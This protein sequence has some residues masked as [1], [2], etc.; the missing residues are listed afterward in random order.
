MVELVNRL[1][2]YF[3]L[4][5]DENTG[6]ALT[7]NEIQDAHYQR[8]SQLQLVAFKNFKRPLEEFYLTNIAKI[9]DKDSF[10]S[11]I[12][13]LS[14]EELIKLCELVYIR[15]K[16]GNEE[17]F[18]RSFLLEALAF[19][20]QRP[21]NPIDI[22][23]STPLYPTEVTLFDPKLLQAQLYNGSQTLSIPKLGT[24]FLSVFDYFYRNFYLYQ[25]E[26]LY[27]IWQDIEDV[28][29]R[30]NATY[31]ASGGGSTEFMGWARMGIRVQGMQIVK[32]S[33]PKLGEAV[34]SEVLAELTIDLSKLSEKHQIEWM[35]LKPFDTLFLTLV[36]AKNMND[37]EVNEDNTLP[38]GIK[39]IRGCE[40]AQLLTPDGK[41]IDPYQ[42]QSPDKAFQA[43]DGRYL[44][45]RVKLDPNQYTED[46]KLIQQNFMPDIYTNF[47]LLIRRNPRENQFKS[48]L[49]TIRDLIDAGENSIPEWLKGGLLGYDDV[50]TLHYS[51]LLEGEAENIDFR[52]TFLDSDHLKESFSD[53]KFIINSEV[54][55]EELQP[56]FKIEFQG[57][58][59]KKKKKL[60]KSSASGKTTLSITSYKFPNLGPFNQIQQNLNTIK[61]TPT[62]VEAIRSGCNPGLTMIVGPPGTGKTDV[63]VQIISNLYHNNPNQRVL[64]VTHSNHALNRLFEK[65]QA[66]DID[67]NHLLRLGHG[68]DELLGGA[69]FGKY[70]RLDSFLEKRFALLKDTEK[71]VTSLGFQG[72]NH[73]DT[74]E[75]SVYFFEQHV[76]PSWNEYLEQIDKL[77]DSEDSAD[78]ARGL[79]ISKF[80]FTSYFSDAP[81]P[82]F[83]ES[84]SVEEL[85]DSALG[86]YRHLKSLYDDLFTLR[87]LE[88]LRNSYDRANYLLTNCARIVAMTCTHAALKR[89]EL[90][91]LGFKY[92]TVIMEEAGQILEIET[93]IPL[94]LQSS[95]NSLDDENTGNQVKRVI[96]LGDHAQLPPIVKGLA[97]QNYGNMECSMF[98][99]LIQLDVQTITLDRQ[100]RAR[101]KIA[102]LYRMRYPTLQ[103]LPKV[104]E[105]EEYL[106]SNTGLSHTFQ[107]INVED[108]QGKGE[109]QPQ[110]YFYQNLGEAEYLVSMYQYMRLLGYPSDKITILTTYAGQKALIQDV[111]EKRCGWNDFFKPF[112]IVSTVDGYQGE[113][114][115]YILLSLVRT[116]RVGYIR[117]IR[118]WTTALSRA[119]LGLY[120]FCRQALFSQ[121]PELSQSLRL[122]QSSQLEGKLSLVEGE[123]YPTK[124]TDGEEKEGDRLIGD[125]IEMG[126]LVFEMVES[127]NF[128]KNDQEEYINPE[129]L[130]DTNFEE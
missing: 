45:V 42:L 77:M 27:S 48:V 20:Y 73:A 46:T 29:R 58:T 105:S 34:P 104:Q 24:E 47:N 97:F 128:I 125:V 57:K 121:V 9:D 110:P 118:R 1:K 80:P 54:N 106:S 90:I 78:S 67:D 19:K 60:L 65:I 88:L 92:N 4:E 122:I 8:L 38:Y 32:V 126:K 30:L 10:I 53:D 44:S 81:Q 31:V 87:P 62:Q 120:I 55:L 89:Q 22:L 14:T 124:R 6:A 82:I 61:F 21:I 33:K 2:L 63:A 107:L 85:K 119:R 116:S 7:P 101:P 111:L 127:G 68:T 108:Y 71:L 3:Q 13:N 39:Y 117:D 123:I 79:I 112:P 36:D 43:K 40:V 113:Q 26:S 59:S 12:N 74:C 95:T 25:Y 99:R 52:D 129:D 102:D 93:A 56:P 72:A 83:S 17:Y 23:R 64:L 114:N 16:S 115:D 5:V 96:L 66:L 94:L 98:D 51:Y 84:A 37:E 41:N 18:E 50:R 15:T 35:G 109:T 28:L 69:Q 75:T 100:G 70:G 130:A 103:D 91:R 76:L 86:C 11:H 49:E